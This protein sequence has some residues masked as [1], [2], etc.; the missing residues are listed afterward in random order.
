MTTNAKTDDNLKPG[1][2]ATT[3]P[4]ID[5]TLLT[6]ALDRCESLTRWDAATLRPWLWAV[7]SFAKTAAAHGETAKA[8]NAMRELGRIRMANG[9]DSE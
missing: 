3:V 4:T 6:C 7:R 5:H 8:A 2:S 9:M 1:K